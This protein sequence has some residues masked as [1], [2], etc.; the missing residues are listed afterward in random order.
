M[1]SN[2]ELYQTN[3]ESAELKIKMWD[4][5]YPGRVV[6]YPNMSAKDEELREFFMKKNARV[7]LSIGID[8]D[9]INDVVHF[10]LA[11]PRQWAMWSN[12]QYFREGDEKHHAEYDPDKAN[13]LLD[14]EGYADKD[15]DGF[16]LLPS[17]K[18]LGWTVEIDPEQGDIPPTMEVVA[19]QWNDLGIEVKLKP[20]NRQLL[21]QLY[22]QNDL[23]MTTWEGD[24]SDITW[25]NASRAVIPGRSNHSWTRPWRLWL[26]SKGQVP[27]LEEEPPDWVQDQA[28]DFH[29]FK[30]TVD[31]EA[32]I[33]IAHRMFDRF[34]EYLPCFS[35]CGV[36]QPVVIKKNLT[37]F[38]D[39]GIWG[40]SVIRAVPAHPEQFFFKT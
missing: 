7:A 30:R 22:D 27:E 38:P 17:G 24:I 2:M 40:F 5:V 28:A 31:P 34:Y 1:L 14:E 11:E 21:N 12:S 32:R 15:G 39:W 10:G 16:R 25:P 29:E 8:R 19:Q 3:L 37:N 36:P 4:S 9:E 18:R 13:Q 35:T 6:I 23:P 33:E 26:W 20:T